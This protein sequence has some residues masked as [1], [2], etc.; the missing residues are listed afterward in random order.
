MKRFLPIL[1]LLALLPSLAFA[2]HGSE[3]DP[4]V[5]SAGTGPVIQY[6]EIEVKRE[7]ETPRFTLR[8]QTD[9]CDTT[10]RVSVFR[11]LK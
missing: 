7:I 1:A 4:G 5:N 10:S 9:T 6:C 8:L 2:A 3:W 11:D